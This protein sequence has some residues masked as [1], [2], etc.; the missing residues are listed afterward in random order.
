[1]MHVS[2]C[3]C[4]SAF[5]V[6]ITSTAPQHQCESLQSYVPLFWLTAAVPVAIQYSVL[7]MTS[8]FVLH[9]CMVYA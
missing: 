4:R 1:M 5:I 9:S 7:N 2:V 3:L 6:D 8:V